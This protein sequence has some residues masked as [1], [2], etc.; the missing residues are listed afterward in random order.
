MLL[1]TWHVKR[2]WLKH[3]LAKVPD[4]ETRLQLFLDLSDIMM[5]THL[6]TTVAEDPAVIAAGTATT[7]LLQQVQQQLQQFCDKWQ[8][9]QPAASFIEYFRSQWMS[10]AGVYNGSAC[11]QL[12]ALPVLGVVWMKMVAHLLVCDWWSLSSD[13]TQLATCYSHML[14]TPAF[15]YCHVCAHVVIIVQRCGL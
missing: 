15:C 13:T 12:R 10:R 3:L 7:I 4:A 5:G 2:S 9:H 11:R 8:A 1:C 14:T 6:D